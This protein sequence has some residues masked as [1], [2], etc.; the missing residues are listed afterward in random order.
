MIGG[1]IPSTLPGLIT[2]LVS[3]NGTYGGTVVGSTTTGGEAPTG[4]VA[5]DDG[6][7]EDLDGVGFGFGFVDGGAVTLTELAAI[8]RL[9]IGGLVAACAVAVS[10]TAD[11]P[12]AGAMTV[13]CIVNDAGAVDVASGP[14][15]QPP[16]PLPL[17]HAA[18]NTPR[19][20]EGPALRL[21]HAEGVGPYGAQTF[22]VNDAAWPPSTLDCARVTLTHSA[23]VELAADKPADDEP[24]DDEPAEEAEAEPEDAD[25]EEDAEAEEDADGDGD[26]DAA[27]TGRYSHCAPGGSANDPTDANAA[28]FPDQA[29]T[30]RT[31]PAVV[32][33]ALTTAMTRRLRVRAAHVAR[34]SVRRRTRRGRGVGRRR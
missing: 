7:V 21:T 13:A 8:G 12:L 23:G 26:G 19:V 16:P 24:A 6:F 30:A 31:T 32:A 18:V 4:E 28:S 33:T 10:D 20:P 15:S 27:A 1:S 14:S 34:R 9:L 29:T 3:G 22:T 17:G 25:A 2:V 11:D 5:V